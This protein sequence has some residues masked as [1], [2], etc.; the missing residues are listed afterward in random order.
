MIGNRSPSSFV[1]SQISLTLTTNYPNI[2]ID[3]QHK[4]DITRFITKTM[5]LLL[6][7]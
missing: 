5:V 6:V 4:I 3:L 1:L 2:Y 7:K